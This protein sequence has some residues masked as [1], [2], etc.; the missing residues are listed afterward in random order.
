MSR[1]WYKQPAASW[2]EALPLGNGSLGAVVFGQP[3]CELLQ[4]NHDTLW[5]GGPR[6]TINSQG[7]NALREIRRLIM[8][9]EDYTAA[10][11][12]CHHLQGPDTA[13]YQPLGDLLFKQH[14]LGKIR[15]YEREL[16]L[17]N[18]ILTV[19]FQVDDV[20]YKREFFISYPHQILVGRFT[21]ER[22]GKLSPEL[23]GAFHMSSQQH[24]KVQIEDQCITL[25]G[26]CLGVNR[27]EEGMGFTVQLGIHSIVGE[28]EPLRDG[29]GVRNASEV[30]VILSS[31]T[32]FR[33]FDQQPNLPEMMVTER[34]EKL[35]ALAQTMSYEQL[36]EIHISDYDRLYSR[37]QIDL[38]VGRDELPTDERLAQVQN[39][40]HDHG[41]IALY[42]QYG[43]YLL[44]A[45]SRQG[46]QP[47]NLQ[48]IWNKELDPPW[49]SNYTLNIN[50]EM[51][52]WLAEN[53]SL[54]ECH[55][56]LFTMI[57]EIN[58][59]G[60]EVA[61]KL[62]GC[63][64]WVASHNTDIWRLATPV[65]GDPVWAI[66]QMGGVWLCQ[67][68]WE[69]FA[70][71]GDRQFLRNTAYPLMKGAAQFCLDWLV[72]HPSG[73]LVTC[74]STSPE[75]KFV[76]QEG[77]TASVS[78]S[79]TM[80]IMLI[81]ELFTN[82]IEASA[83]LDVDNEFREELMR[84]RDQLPPLQ[85]GSQGQLLE[86]YKEF[87]EAEP[88]HRHISHLYGFYPGRRITVDNDPQL[89]QA[90]RRSLELRLSHGSGHTGWSRGWIINVWA[91]LREGDLA[92]ENLH[93]L[94]AHSTL[95]NLFDTHPPFQIDGNFGGTAGIAEMLLQSHAG[96]LHLL[97]ALPGRWEKGFVRGLRARGGYTVDIF[98]NEGRLAEAV[99]TAAHN[100]EC[101]VRWEDQEMSWQGRTGEKLVVRG[102]VQ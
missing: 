72:P 30:V 2:D 56:P 36:R 69:H 83:I 51:N 61:Q 90:V 100:G 82:C 29:L 14:G 64:G 80:D 4:L 1:L 9:E 97:P 20:T 84:T 42:F 59:T 35:L 102:K 86:W 93:A 32:S 31:A 3:V 91:R 19:S 77:V 43:R 22:G 41:L 37:V 12:L 21:A 7:K 63:R 78:M 45:S 71:S 101:L 60:S 28:L 73:Y 47:A 8:E 92:Y 94:L 34:C 39:G 58:E 67:H 49:R 11:K 89:V 65:S 54:P 85:I 25:K 13:K 23:N 50:A 96:F 53:C 70:F 46:S 33:G 81:W 68:L 6:N 24:H 76:V 16:N 38:G 57:R 26:Q 40:A 95:P 66:W 98:W 52:Y 18:A 88:G 62:Y 44:I 79:S 55:E 17:E 87:E 48:G 99:I 5:T 27:Q 75:N 15:N 74:P 10:E